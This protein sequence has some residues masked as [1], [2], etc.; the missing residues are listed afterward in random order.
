MHGKPIDAK[1]WS[2]NHK[3]TNLTPGKREVAAHYL[4]PTRLIDSIVPAQLQEPMILALFQRKNIGMH[5][6]ELGKPNSL[7]RRQ[8]WNTE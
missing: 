2:D 4:S 3:L 1:E 8:G 7:F 6:H 5:I